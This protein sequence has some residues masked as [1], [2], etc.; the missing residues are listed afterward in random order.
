MVVIGWIRTSRDDR[1]QREGRKWRSTAWPAPSNQLFFPSL[2]SLLSHL[3]HKMTGQASSSPLTIEPLT[4]APP[5][6]T[7]QE[8]DAAT[9]ATPASFA[10]IPPR[11][12]LGLEGVTVLIEP[13]ISVGDVQLEGALKGQMWATEG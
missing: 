7:A 5:F 11:L 10:D 3:T 13:A 12:V 6:L 1:S 2:P 8:H 4:T 9:S